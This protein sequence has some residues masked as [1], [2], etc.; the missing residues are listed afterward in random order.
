MTLLRLHALAVA[1]SAY[2]VRGGSCFLQARDMQLPWTGYLLLIA[3][4]EKRL[5]YLSRHTS[6]LSFNATFAYL[7]RSYYTVARLLSSD[8]SFVVFED[9]KQ[10]H[11]P[12]YVLAI[13]KET[14]TFV[15][16]C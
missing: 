2:A 10:K 1:A 9:G 11:G 12:T 14:T 8:R 15:F 5:L 13:G 6:C 4:L 3:C 7:N 16:R